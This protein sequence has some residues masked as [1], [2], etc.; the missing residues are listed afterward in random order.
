MAKKFRARVGSQRITG[1]LNPAEASYT[2]SIR[3]QMDQIEKNVTAFIDG[4]KGITPEVLKRALQPTFEK[5]QIYVPYD[6]GNL[7][8]SGYLEVEQKGQRIQAEIGYG[9]GSQPHYA[10]YVHE[11]VN[12]P[13]AAPTRSKYLQAAIEED[14]KLI[15]KRLRAAYKALVKV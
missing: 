8:D 14:S 3:A 7:H 5:S 2:R 11:M 9:K 10:A 4:V 15:P 1:S 6:T 13:H 12:I